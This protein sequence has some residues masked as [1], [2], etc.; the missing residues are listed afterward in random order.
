MIDK[1]LTSYVGGGMAYELLT[2]RRLENEKCLER[3]GFKVYSQ[4]DEDGII[5]EIFNRIGT[6][7]KIFVEFGVQNGLECNS[8]YLLHKG[9]SGLW[10]EG[11]DKYCAEIS[12]R[13][14]PVIKTEQLKIRNA[15]ITKDNINFLIAEGGLVGEIDL[16]SVDIDGNDYYVWKAINVIQ[17]R[18][19]VIEYNAKFPPNHEWVMAYNEKHSWDG[20]DW[21][22]ASLKALELLGRELGYQLVG[23][24]LIGINAFFVNRELAKDLFIEP[25]TAEEL[26]NPFRFGQ[27]K[28]SNGHPARYCLVNQLPNLGLINYDPAKYNE[29]RNIIGQAVMS[30]ELNEEAARRYELIKEKSNCFLKPPFTNSIFFLPNANVDFLQKHIVLFG[31]YRE[32]QELEKIFFDFKGGLLSKIIEK[33]DSVILDI[34]AN[35]GNHTLYYANELHAGKVISFEAV[36]NTFQILKI[37]VEVNKLQDRVQIYNFGLSD[38]PGKA[39]IRNYNPQNIG[40]TDLVTGQ[41]EITLRALDEFEIPKVDFIKIDVEGMEPQVL[42]GAINTIKNSRPFIVLE[43]YSDKFPLVEEFFSKLNYLYERVSDADYLFYPAEYENYHDAELENYDVVIPLASSHVEQMKVNLPFIK[44]NLGHDKIILLCSEKTFEHF[45]D[46]DVEF[47]NEDE[48]LAGMNFETV[49][50]IISKRG[51]NIERASWYLKQFLKMYYAFVCKK[52]HYL[53]WDADTIPIKPIYFLNRRGKMFFNMKAERHLPYFQLIQKFFGDKLKFVESPTPSFISE[54]M[55]MNSE[56]MRELVNEMG[57]KDFWKN[58]LNAI[59]PK[60]LSHSGF[61]EYETYGTYLVNKYPQLYQSRPLKTMRDG[62]RIFRRVL[63]YDELKLLP[64]ETISFENWQ[65]KLFK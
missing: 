51:G 50:E 12:A 3:Y 63:S 18:A 23:T 16:L 38:K 25:A 58:I 30:K 24:N 44:K 54:G 46:F 15:F 31:D 45:K 59:E 53:I 48:I 20:S 55:I 1:F 42:N 11:S 4:N 39:A 14:F 64:Y 40:G 27:L 28:Y 13:F 8:H 9:W 26:Y 47:L 32:R 61:S 19:V 65:I 29:R 2:A 10:L 60:D 34:G 43:S 7:N 35:I 49:A 62:G 37:N 56:I 6:T 36:A 21:H 33:P 52:S 5:E 57:G 22:G 17:P 41:G